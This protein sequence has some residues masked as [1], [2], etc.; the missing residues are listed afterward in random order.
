MSSSNNERDVCAAFLLAI[1]R[2]SFSMTGDGEIPDLISEFDRSNLSNHNSPISKV[3]GHELTNP[4][5][6]EFVKA[7]H[8][9]WKLFLSDPTIDLN[10]IRPILLYYITENR[11]DVK[12]AIEEDFTDDWED[13]WEDDC[14]CT[15][16]SLK[17]ED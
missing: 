13:D 3:M 1:N 15:R 12:Y 5:L 4:C 2:A 8:N 10:C 16:C 7:E 17:K 9:G 6:K 11:K 14:L